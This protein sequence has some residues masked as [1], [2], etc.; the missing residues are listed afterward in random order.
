MEC[1][2]SRLTKMEMELGTSTSPSSTLD[3]DSSLLLAADTRLSFG[4]FA[5][6]IS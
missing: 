1:I 4:T 6:M 3:L 2:S 5:E